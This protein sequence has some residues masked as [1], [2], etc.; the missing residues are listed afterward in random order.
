MCYHK[1]GTACENQIEKIINCSETRTK[2]KRRGF[3]EQKREK[4]VSAVLSK[5]TFKN[6]DNKHVLV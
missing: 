6:E 5:R 1:S 2:S 3:C 4:K